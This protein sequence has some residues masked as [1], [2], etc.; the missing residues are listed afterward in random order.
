MKAVAA[1]GM[2]AFTSLGATPHINFTR[3]PTTVQ[4]QFREFDLFA[5]YKFSLG[6]VDVTLGNIAFII[7]REAQTFETWVLTTPGLVWTVTGT[8]SLPIGPSTRLQA[9]SSTESTFGLALPKFLTSRLQLFI[10]R[11]SITREINRRARALS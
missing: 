5:A 6:P 7:D 10:I 4:T 2:G 11:P 3:F 8:T 9:S 1:G